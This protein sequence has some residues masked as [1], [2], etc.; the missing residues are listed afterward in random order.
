MNNKPSDQHELAKLEAKVKLFHF[1]RDI[2]IKC[3]KEKSLEVWII[4]ME[5]VSAI[6]MASENQ[7]VS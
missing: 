1:L 3:A 7:D 4:Y 6:A 5:I 2:G